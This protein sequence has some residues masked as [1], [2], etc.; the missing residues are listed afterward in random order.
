[1]KHHV[2]N[3]TIVF[4]K[5]KGKAYVHTFLNRPQLADLEMCKYG[6]ALFP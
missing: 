4:L 3:S 5:A 1:M 6:I 2:A